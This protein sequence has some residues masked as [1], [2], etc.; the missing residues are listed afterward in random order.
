MS[1]YQYIQNVKLSRPLKKAQLKD[2][3]LNGLRTNLYRAYS[4]SLDMRGLLLRK[5]MKFHNSIYYE[6]KN[7]NGSINKI[8]IKSGDAI[9]IE[10]AASNNPTYAIV[11][12]VI[13]HRGNNDK[14]YTFL[15]IKWYNQISGPDRLLGC[16]RFELC[17]NEMWQ[18]IFPINIVD[19]QPKVHFVHSCT[20][21]CNLEK[22][23]FSNIYYKNEY[24]FRP[25]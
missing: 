12:A 17:E 1:P 4:E 5:Q 25:V 2:F 16:P 8:K 13:S 21:N 15:Y 24:I 10:E 20:A 23:D 3:N 22:H 9:E 14:D 19:Q 11:K 7:E 18:V 6:V